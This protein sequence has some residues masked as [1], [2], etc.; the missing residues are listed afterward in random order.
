MS[1]NHCVRRPLHR[2]TYVAALLSGVAACALGAS[3]A[4]AQQAADSSGV[5]EIVVTATHRSERLQDVPI[6]VTALSAETLSDLNV[7]NFDDLIKT[8]PGV[9]IASGGPS[10]SEIYMR[11]LAQGGR[12]G[13]QGSGVTAPFPNVAVYLDEQSEQVP[14]R[15]L[16][17]YAAD[18]QRVEVLEGPQ[19]TGFGSGAEAGVLRYITN[20]PDLY[21]TEA[22]FNA[23]VAGTAHG[24]PSGGGDATLNVPVING[25]AALRLVIYDDRRGGYINNVPGTFTR[26]STD[27][28]IHY[29]GY[30]NNI[31]GPANSRNSANNANMTGSAINPVTYKGGR[32]EGAW[33]FDDDWDVLLAESYQHMDAEGVFYETPIG[34][35]GK[36]L[37]D[38]SVQLFNP[39]YDKDSFE[40]T[41]LTLNGRIGDLSLVYNGSYLVRDTHQQQDYTNYARGTYGDY[42]QCLSPT[43]AAAVGAAAGC[44]SPSAVWRENEH[45]THLTQELRLKTPDDWRLRAIGGLFYEHFQVDA[46]TDYEYK[47]APGFTLIAPPPGAATNNPNLRDANDSFQN[48]VLR[49]YSQRAAYLSLDYDILPKELTVTAAGRYYD[50]SNEEEGSYS[51]S[52]GCFNAGPAPCIGNHQVVNGKSNYKG[53]IGR[54]NV[55][56]KIDPD[57][58]VYYTWS[59]GFRP[60]GFNRGTENV[61]GETFFKYAPDS[62]TNNEIGFKTSWFNRRLVV[63]GAIYMEDWDDVQTQIFNPTEYGI[64]TF[65]TNGPNFK[66]YGAEV[67]ATGRVT[68]AFTLF[69]SGELNSSQQENVPTLT[70]DNGYVN[71]NLASPWAAVGSTLAQAPTFKGNLRGRYEFEWGDYT[72][73]LQ[74]GV[75]AATATHS[76]IGVPQTG[77]NAVYNSNFNEQGYATADISAGFSMGQMTFTAFCDNF[78]D[79]RVQEFITE[80]QLIRAVYIDRPL[81]A[82]IRLKYD[83]TP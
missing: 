76:G 12:G 63:N 39:T 81:T 64:L 19:G 67:Q 73:F 1:S 18:L 15:N 6:A 47:T 55:T 52:F 80:S 56:W 30:T 62:L 77:A 66:V 16:D 5:Q 26:S 8:L 21:K 10:Q 27:L 43:Q 79:T 51:G 28:G 48:D 65:T 53:A 33:R 44:Y 60:G 20:K 17:I 40:N 42:Y 24:D 13:L 14:G 72:P 70:G 35:D 41:A 9:T 31:P 54:F 57:V 59:Q 58:M 25:T 11:G 46:T 50:F 69:A 61:G 7:S 34:V 45:D 36:G 68:D 29:A 23:T 82:G 71:P 74:V 78:T 49:G 38:L 2:R 4:Y 3:Q 32:L 83:F 37:P 22:I 75:T